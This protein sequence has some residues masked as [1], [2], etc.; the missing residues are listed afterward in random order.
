MAIAD[1][2]QEILRS[3]KSQKKSYNKLFKK[4]KTLKPK[5]L[6]ELFF[7]AHDEAF[8]EIDC[9]KCGNCC[10]TTSPVFKPEDIERLAS[11]F[12]L[13]SREFIHKYLYKDADDDYVL[14]ETPCPFLLED[15]YCA[16]Y[17]DRPQ[18]CRSFPHTNHR[19]MHNYIN[20][21]RANAKIC[22]AV[23]KV[24]DNLGIKV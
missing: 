24:L 17:E 20:L 21:A 16:V 18:A 14:K 1:E 12:R 15:N 2:Y 13:K 19:K 8:E 6:D 4:I 22:P 10:R 9:L 23:V 3:F 7:E 11:R 5:E